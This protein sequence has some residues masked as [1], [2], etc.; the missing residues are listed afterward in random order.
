MI[1]FEIEA[2]VNESRQVTVTLPPEAQTGRVKMR[3]TI[4]PD[5]A[6]PTLPRLTAIMPEGVD[7]VVHSGVFRVVDSENPK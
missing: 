7:M 5:V 1:A 6:V 4:E 2:D 3:I